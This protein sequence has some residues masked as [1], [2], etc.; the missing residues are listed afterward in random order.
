MVVQVNNL[1]HE[2]KG[3]GHV[4]TR[5]GSCVFIRNRRT[6]VAV[7]LKVWFGPIASASPGNLLEMQIIGSLLLSIESETG[8]GGWDI[9]I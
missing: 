5:V 1:I 2:F 8:G 4:Q 6:S 3:T 9:P 7:I